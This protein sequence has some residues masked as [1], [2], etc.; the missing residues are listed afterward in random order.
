MRTLVIGLDCR[1]LRAAARAVTACRSFDFTT[2]PKLIHC[3][4][5][6][7]P[8]TRTY[9]AMD[10]AIEGKRAAAHFA[11]NECIQVF[12]VKF[13][14]FLVILQAFVH[15]VNMC[16]IFV[17]SSCMIHIQSQGKGKTRVA[18]V[19]VGILRVEVVVG[20][21]ASGFSKVWKITRWTFLRTHS[22]QIKSYRLH[23][24]CSYGEVQS[25]DDEYARC[26]RT[27]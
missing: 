5:S 22:L 8:S 9:C 3:G 20:H 27:R 16:I 4:C 17:S 6:L 13:Q 1:F 23:E 19:R 12:V 18:K 2:E 11:V 25:S 26:G 7:R 21:N 15:A 10:S 24:N 14:E